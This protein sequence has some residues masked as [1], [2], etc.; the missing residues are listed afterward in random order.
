VG[1][2]VEILLVARRGLILAALALAALALGCGR[3]AAAGT[4][5]AQDYDAFWLWGGVRPTPALAGART[6]YMLQG[7]VDAPLGR[8][9]AAGVIAQGGAVPRLRRGEVWLA[10]RANTLRWTPA[11]YAQLN[12]RLRRWRAAGN[13]VVGVQIDFDAR[14]RHLNEYATFLADLR[15]RLPADCKLSITGLLDWSSQGDSAALNALGAVVDEVVLQTYQGRR[16]IGGY[17]TY[18]A[19]LRRMTSP[20]KVGLVEGGEWTAPSDLAANPWF[21]GYVVFLKNGP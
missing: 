6:L 7:M 1:Q 18:L 16:T 19:G 10:Y 9:T 8:D 21:R 17:E 5:R 11:V 3:P 20:F 15:S 12:A 13:P 2:G 14:T 4:V